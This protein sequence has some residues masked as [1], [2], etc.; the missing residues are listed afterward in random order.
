MKAISKPLVRAL[1]L[2]QGERD[3]SFCHQVPSP[4][5]RQ[6]KNSRVRPIAPEHSWL[7]RSFRLCSRLAYIFDGIILY[8]QSGR[9]M[10]KT[11]GE[12]P[13]ERKRR[14]CI[15]GSLAALMLASTGARGQ[16]WEWKIETA[17][18]YGKFT[19]LA[20]DDQG[21]VHLSYVNG[22]AFVSYG[23]RPAG[24]SRW[25]IMTIDKGD[26]FTKITVDHRGNPH[27]C[28]TAYGKLKYSHW[29]GQR[30]QTQQIAEGSG[31]IEFSCSVAVA[32][33]GTPHIA[34]Y[35]TG[36]P[37]GRPYG[38]LKYAILQDGAW[39]A[40]TLDFDNETGKWN[41]M[42]LDAQ[43][44]PLISYSAWR[45]GQ[46]K[47]AYWNGNRWNITSVDSREHSRDEYN[48]G[49]GSSLV[50]DRDGKPLISYYSESKLKYARQQGTRWTNETVDSITWL[51][52]W[53]GFRSSQVLDQS[54][55]PHVCYEDA[56]VL[57]HAF[58]DGK[59][60]HVQVIAPSG[61]EAYRYSAI[62][63]DRE[64]TLYI[65]YHD[66]SDGSLKVAIGHQVSP[67]RVGVT[68]SL[69]QTSLEER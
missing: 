55:F 19:S 51:G 12:K 60:W 56:G 11:S 22:D 8:F 50:L 47:F 34:W 65:S 43:G 67:P 59:N 13:L 30:W 10:R 58:G 28:S 37:D 26:S 68:A 33:G 18:L 27:I 32:P 25:F 17:D 41:S 1:Q 31:T 66:P 23:I 48:I 69:E 57:K 9:N 21:N 42:V 63:I 14:G 15:L 61:I 35:Q 3:L 16:T 45:S 5:L 36:L 54:G 6:G 44:F 39:R 62:A 53:L 49:Q 7:S 29:D 46:L 40:R 20:T 2:P 38:H 24:S 64:G 4:G 52:G